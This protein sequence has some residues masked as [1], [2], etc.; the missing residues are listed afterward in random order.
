[1]SDWIIL[2]IS[3]VFVAAM[4]VFAA[5][6]GFRDTVRLDEAELRRLAAGEGAALEEWAI[7]RGQRAA[8]ARLSG[9]RFMAVRVMGDGISVRVARVEAARITLR[10]GGVTLS[11]ADTGFPP[12][13]LKTQEPPAAWLASLA[14]GG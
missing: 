3:T 14:R 5:L 2:A 7:A 11:F 8:A 6:L 9:G 1:M 10:R 13:Y 12:L 4:V